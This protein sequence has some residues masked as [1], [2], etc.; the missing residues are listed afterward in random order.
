MAYRVTHAPHLCV[1]SKRQPTATPWRR[2]T[3]SGKQQG[4]RPGC[5]T[6]TK[7]EDQPIQED[8]VSKNKLPEQRLEDRLRREA[9]KLGLKVVKSRARNP[10]H[11]AFGSYWIVDAEANVTVAGDSEV[12]LT[13]L[14]VEEEIWERRWLAEF[15]ET[16]DR[17]LEERRGKFIP[18]SDGR[19]IDLAEATIED[20]KLTVTYEMAKKQRAKAFG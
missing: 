11:V 13:L 4:R 7:P 10:N 3:P 5:G 12:G 16:L 9:K 14:Q 18:T 15:Q 19:L 8:Q 1:R 20:M 17:P 2:S 6:R